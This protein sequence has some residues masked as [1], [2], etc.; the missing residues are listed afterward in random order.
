MKLVHCLHS[1]TEQADHTVYQL[2]L[3]TNAAMIN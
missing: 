2:L 3:R 1:E